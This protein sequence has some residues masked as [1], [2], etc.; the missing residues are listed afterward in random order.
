[1]PVNSKIETVSSVNEQ[2]T[3]MQVRNLEN[4]IK[5]VLDCKNS[6]LELLQFKYIDKRT[7]VG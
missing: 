2:D 4:R 1:V 7:L 6:D 5:N 3:G